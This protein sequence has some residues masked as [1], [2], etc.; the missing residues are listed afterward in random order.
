MKD[1]RCCWLELGF[2]IK[3]YFSWNHLLKRI[4]KVNCSNQHLLLIRKTYFSMFA[5]QTLQKIL[6]SI[7]THFNATRNKWIFN[8]IFSSLIVRMSCMLTCH[9]SLR[10]HLLLLM[11]WSMQ[12]YENFLLTNAW[13]Y[14]LE[15]NL[16]LG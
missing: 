8:L 7:S 4:N 16:K 3:S 6:M 15:Y 2:D 14:C 11:F 5:Y 10:N 9:F 12:Q 13:Y 1:K